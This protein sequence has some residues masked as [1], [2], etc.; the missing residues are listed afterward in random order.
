MKTPARVAAL[1]F[2]ALSL[3]SQTR[4]D[5]AK[6]FDVAIA[7]TRVERSAPSPGIVDATDE[8]ANR[9][10]APIVIDDQ[11]F[12]GNIGWCQDEQTFDAARADLKLGKA[13][14][15]YAYVDRVNRVLGQKKDWDT[16]A[17]LLNGRYDVSKTYAVEG[18]AYLIDAQ[19][20]PANS[21]RTVGLRGT[22]RS[23]LGPVALAYEASYARQSNYRDQPAR[24]DLDFYD[25]AVAATRG[26][27]TLRLDYQE[28]DGD[29]RRGFTTPLAT[30]HAFN[31][32]SDAFAT[33][34]GNK[35]FVDGLGD[36]NAALSLKPKWKAG[37]LARPEFILAWHGFQDRRFGSD[38]G[39]EWDMSAT[40]NLT[41]RVFLLLK[42]ADFKAS[43][44]AP[45]GAAAPPASRTKLWLSV[46]FRL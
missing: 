24:F 14:L 45:T 19:N 30:A 36:Y 39:H 37:R 4:A 3:A 15:V 21:S 44:A 25:A 23:K 28:L 31:G 1:A 18:F 2:M 26:L 32:W 6:S 42:Y 16:Q 17:H 8:Q 43:A 20:A 46:E 9:L 34:D 33:P 12:V 22:G 29:G 13:T 40:A 41:D 38:L 10:T 11:R 35:G 7:T 27:A 5:D